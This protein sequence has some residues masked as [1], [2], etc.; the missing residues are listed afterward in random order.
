MGFLWFGTKD[1]L[2]RFDGYHFK[3]F[4]IEGEGSNFTPDAVSCIIPDKN[5]VLW[6][7]CKK[8]LFRF[9]TK[10][11]RLVRYIDSLPEINGIQLDRKGRLWFIS[12]YTLYRFNFNTKVL[13]VFPSRQYFRAT[14]ICLSDDGHIWAST[15][16]GFIERFNDTTEAF[17]VFD[18]FSHSQMASSKWINKIYPA[19]KGSLFIGTT[20][21]GLKQFNV[22]TSNYI[23]LL[24]FNPD[25]TTIYIRDIK[26]STEN[27]FWIATESGI[28]ILNT[29]TKKFINLKKKILDPYS[30]S[31]NAV[32]ALCR[33]ADGGMWAGTYFDGINYY[34]KQLAAFYKY[35]PDNSANAISG[36]VVREIC[37]DHFENIWIGTED[38][39]L[40]KLNTK[41][42]I[43]TQYKPT[44]NCR[45]IAYTNIHGLLVVGNELWI[46]TFEHGLDVMNIRTGQVVRHYKAGLGE[47]DLK[48]NFIVTLMQTKAG[49]ILVGSSNSLFKYDPKTNGFDAVK[50]THPSIFVSA[51]LE[52]H[53]GTIWIGT[54]YK[55]VDFYNPTTKQKGHFE[56]EPANEN[57]LSTNSINS[58]YEDSKHNLWFATEGG[59]LCRLSSNRKTFIR[60]TTKNGLPS[61]YIFKVLEDNKSHLW[62]S[63]LKGLVN[64]NPDD[65][66]VKIYSKDNGLLN[67]QF[68]YNSGFKDAKG[69]MYFGGIKGMIS[70]MP[71]DI[72]T[73]ATVPPVYITGFQV[74]NK[75]LDIKEDSDILK[76]PIIYTDEITLPYNRSSISIDF[77]ALGF[78]S[79]ETT[80]YSYFMKGLDKEWTEIKQ[81]RKIYFTN[82]TSGKYVFNIKAA[83]NGNQP[84]KETQLTII[85]LPPFWATLWARLLYAAVAIALLYYL[86]RTYHNKIEG[87]KEKE[88]YEAKI[89]FFTNVTHEIR[90]P[91]T[92]I[93]GPVDNLLELVDQYPA[94]K[95]DV[96]T[97]ERNTDRLIALITQILDF[98]QVETKGF[99]IDF[100]KVNISQMLNDA[101]LNYTD[102]AKKKEIT[103]TIYL[104]DNNIYALA[105]EEALYKIFS[106]LFQN[107]VKYADTKINIRLLPP[108]ADMLTFSIV[109]EN[110][111]AKIP[112]DMKEKIFEPFYR[113]KQSFKQQGTGIGLALARSLTAL[114][115]GDLYLKDNVDSMN[116]FVL[117]LP[118][119]PVEKSKKTE[120]NQ[121]LD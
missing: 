26:Q 69:R 90:T 61:N 91:L 79:P 21:Q 77:A 8:G 15:T 78:V 93:K 102:L 62:V 3:L 36:S 14:S 9:D 104:P 107:A 12:G 118:L 7:G 75:E 97:L 71:D 76:K 60:V 65:G 95:A 59:G 43:I 63:T 74:Q 105:D 41:T 112:V 52:D 2:N 51:M 103:Y 13:T 120:N 80:A 46:G 83:I 16:H 70:F 50:E 82:L 110:D 88:I 108:D 86:F 99:S 114:H 24:T 44:G 33:D 94:I 68:N 18:V 29:I 4:N 32:Y 37:E 100:I 31:D 96:V 56:N 22:A 48:S 10:K 92:L 17:E 39:G 111:G 57:S 81:N 119:K 116:I 55:G 64:L 35:F 58:I 98:R 42:G 30:L 54:Q 38:A 49:D 72:V 66:T 34:S 1:G 101:Y 106:N 23:D 47:K 115:N 67:N 5:N 27:E 28:F 89:D 85:I 113:L 84:A 6:V 40:N 109:F 25:K 20:S 121:M 73:T 117:C 87:K 11:E 53:T 45:G 19:G